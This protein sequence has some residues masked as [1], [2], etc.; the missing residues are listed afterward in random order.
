MREKDALVDL[1]PLLVALKDVGLSLDLETRGDEAGK[2]VGRLKDKVLD[3]NEARELASERAINGLDMGGEETRAARARTVLD[4]LGGAGLGAVAPRLWRKTIDQ[5]A[6]ERP[7]LGVTRAILREVAQSA[8]F[9]PHPVIAGGCGQAA[10][11]Q[12]HAQRIARKR[13]LLVRRD[14]FALR[15][16]ITRL[17]LPCERSM[18]PGPT[19]R[20]LAVTPT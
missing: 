18:V 10:L 19:T 2:S 15:R 12:D 4:R 8:R 14:H 11:A 1:Q 17:A 7:E 13:R 6:S 3:A 20:A 5:R 9:G 16:S